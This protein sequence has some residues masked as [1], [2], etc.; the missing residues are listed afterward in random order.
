MDDQKKRFDLLRES[1]TEDGVLLSPAVLLK[2][3][4]LRWPDRPALV[5]GEERITFEQLFWRACVV[6]TELTKRSFKPN[7]RVLIFYENGIDFYVAYYAVWLAG[8]VVVPLNAFLQDEELEHIVKDAAPAAA[9][10]SRSL[11][12]RFSKAGRGLPIIAVEELLV[13]TGLCEEITFEGRGVMGEEM[14][15]LL[16]TSGTTGLPKGVMLSAKSLLINAM[17][18]VATLDL[19]DHEVVLAALPLF[20]SYMQNTCVWSPLL[21]GA[22]VIIVSKITRRNIFDAFAHKPTAVLGIPQMFGLFCK[23][24]D[25]DFSSVKF[26]FCGGDALHTPI[27]RI[28]ELVYG[29]RLAN[30]YGLTEMAPLVAVN[31]FDGQTPDYC[32]GFP[33]YGV[34]ISIRDE[35]NQELS[36]G[37][38]G[39][40]VVAGE[41]MMQGYY[42]APDATRAVIASGWLD[43]GDLGYLTDG[44]RLVISGRSKDLIINKGFNIYP[45]EIEAVLSTYPGV[46]QVA[47]V[48]VHVGQDEIPCAFVMIDEAD[49]ALERDA[50]LRLREYCLERLAFYK[51]PRW[52]IIK[53]SLPVTTTGKIDKKVLRVL[54]SEILANDKEE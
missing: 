50:S 43:T 41:N 23:L 30:G 44:G 6:A 54:A 27:K 11:H 25:L 18:A 3:A 33:V 46:L 36:A 16:Y 7:D 48:G 4:A 34:Q 12:D 24:R 45:Q 49:V 42:K 29:R 14:G 37:Q 15:A 47:V 32:V 9:L 20:H 53:R 1:I 40:V 17:Q 21:I 22:T 19:G 8:G 51:I 52:F 5:C 10:V 39:R 2:R 31:L 26:C 38:I 28:F 13:C 35:Q